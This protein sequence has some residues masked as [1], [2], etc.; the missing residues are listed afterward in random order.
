MGTDPKL[1]DVGV[2]ES[3]PLEIIVP[4]TLALTLSVALATVRIAE[5][6]VAAAPAAG[7]SLR[8]TVQVSPLFSVALAAQALLEMVMFVA[9]LTETANAPVGVGG[10]FVSVN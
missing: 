1:T 8:P 7:V 6:A 4:V 10:G 2:A 5:T 9:G 3:V